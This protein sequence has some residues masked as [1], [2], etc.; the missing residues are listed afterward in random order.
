MN[1]EQT[2]FTGGLVLRPTPDELKGHQS[3]DAENCD[4]VREVGAVMPRRGIDKYYSRNLSAD[5]VFWQNV[6]DTPGPIVRAVE[7]LYDAL[8]P[9]LCGLTD[10]VARFEEYGDHVI[11]ANGS[12]TL[13][14][15]QSGMNLTV[16]TAF[17]F[18]H[19]LDVIEASELN[20]GAY[21]QSFLHAYGDPLGEG[22]AEWRC[23]YEWERN[24]VEGDT[25]DE[26]SDDFY[27]HSS[28]EGKTIA[29]TSIDVMD[30]CRAVNLG[31]PTG[32]QVSAEAIAA[33][34]AAA[35][36]KLLLHCD[37]NDEG[38]TFTD[39]A[40]GHA[41][42][43]QG[44]ANTETDQQKFGTA[45]LEVTDE[46][47]AV[48][49]PAHS[50]FDLGYFEFGIECWVRFNTVPSSDG[51]RRGLFAVGEDSGYTDYYSI[52]M[53]YGLLR[54]D[55]YNADGFP[56]LKYLTLSTSWTP[57]VDTWYHLYA[58]RG[59]GGDSDEWAL[60]IDG[61][62][63]AT[64]NSHRYIDPIAEDLTVGS[65]MKASDTY[66]GI[67]GFIDEVRLVKGVAP[68]TS[69]FSVPTA[70]YSLAITGTFKYKMTNVNYLGHE[71]NAGGLA[72]ATAAGEIV[73]L[74]IPVSDDP[75]VTARNIYR[76]A[77]GGATY[78]YL[79]A[80]NNNYETTYEDV[81]PDALLGSNLVSTQDEPPVFSEVHDR[82]SLLWGIEAA[83]KNKV[84]WCNAFDDWD[85]FDQN[86]YETFGASSAE[87]MALESLGEFLCVV[88]KTRIWKYNTEVDPEVLSDSYSAV[89]A[90]VAEAVLNLKDA[91]LIV[92]AG[93]MYLFD[94]VKSLKF[95]QKIDPIFDP[96]GDY[97]ERIDTDYLT[98][99]RV[100][101]LD[102]R[103]FVSYTRTGQTTNDRTIVYDRELDSFQGV[104]Q[105][106]FTCFTADKK[107]KV[108]LGVGTDGYIYQLE[109]G[110]DD[111][112]SAIAWNF[113][114]KDYAGEL[115]KGG[116]S[117][118]ES[119]QL[120][121]KTSD[122]LIW[123]AGGKL[124]VDIDPAGDTLTVAIFL[125]GTQ[126]QSRS[127]TDSS[128][129]VKEFRLNPDYHFIRLA[130]L[131]SGSTTG[132]QRFYGFRSY[133]VEVV[134]E[135]Q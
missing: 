41:M 122:K 113:K 34:T 5:E 108:I 14:Y 120:S 81:I 130:L 106:G 72:T 116:V 61:V 123:K 25:L 69:N 58:C 42:T 63:V 21:V 43:A 131:V 6:L 8:R 30:V 114:T 73:S 97:A 124:R 85:A 29:G 94:A 45:S 19:E 134:G 2:K 4:F 87:S 52:A 96:G 110:N 65:M 118:G 100:G 57:T 48:S 33:S 127:F 70:A 99:L 46:D 125:D 27:T 49:T 10:A 18:D 59:W 51:Y 115:I 40:Q 86:N 12:E 39:D 67:D 126:R 121:S 104:I 111:D 36:T 38:T 107:T 16:H 91:L 20:L 32:Q 54:F 83:N 79:V 35:N 17:M 66:Y 133:G 28:C 92:D 132:A 3:Q 82:Q 88:Q 78:Q 71:G 50:D 76:T 26:D 11:V 13:K 117:I 119:G 128:R 101:A 1:F 56:G 23:T 89:G 37:G 9:V 62:A 47:D 102:N 80:V 7:R 90:S 60:C 53:R 44:A 135:G 105:D 103:I 77:N 84:W 129:A 75:Q 74:T 24:Y 109:T 98:N 112:G 15:K 22:N 93:G 55:H 64:T 68:Y 95:S 31:V